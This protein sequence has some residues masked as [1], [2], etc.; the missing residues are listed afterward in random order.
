MSG[1]QP[2]REEAG[3]ESEGGDASSGGGGVS[4]SAVWIQ[5]SSVLHDGI[6]YHTVPKNAIWG[7]VI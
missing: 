6:K 7:G 1:T 5:P 2:C 4:E 3:E